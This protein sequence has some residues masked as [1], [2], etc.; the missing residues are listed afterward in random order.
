MGFKE[1]TPI[2]SQAIPL[3]LAGRDIIG[4]AQT[5]SGKTAAF[6]IPILESVKPGGSLPQALIIT[7]TREL[8]IQV[9]D[10]LAALGKYKQ[11]RLLAVFGG[12]DMDIQAA[13]I[14]HGI[15]IIVGTPGRIVDHMYNGSLDFRDIRHVVIDEAD[16]MFDLGFIDDVRFILEST[17]LERQTLLFSATMLPEI[18]RI[19]SEFLYEPAQVTI[20][21]TAATPPDIR[22]QYVTVAEQKRV[23]T[24]LRILTEEEIEQAIIFCRT[25]RRVDDLVEQLAKRGVTAEGLH[26]DMSQPE[27]IRVMNAF[28]RRKNRLLIA[29]D[30]AARG[31]DV[32]DVSHVINY[33]AP[34]DL[35]SYIHRIGRT[36]RA[37]RKGIAIT[38]VAPDERRFLRSIEKKTG[39]PI[40]PR[41]PDEE[42][43]PPPKKRR[44]A[45]RRR[46]DPGQAVKTRAKIKRRQRVSRRSAI[47]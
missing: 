2:Q 11:V 6:G 17:P 27:R 26:G 24:L 14:R 28:R 8:A 42:P 39:Q 34:A 32:D 9:A 21:Q 29:T 1:P 12:H 41:Y 35:E 10:E 3:A 7:P 36:G 44:R 23:D 18:A 47:R 40:E 43:A 30:V 4:L 45:A 20:A 33:D 37:G 46:P 13:A 16:R 19:A 22:Q 25:K 38:F 15:D 31:I 5:G